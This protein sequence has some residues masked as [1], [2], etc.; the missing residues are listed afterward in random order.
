MKMHPKP[1]ITFIPECF[2]NQGILS[3]SMDFD[4]CGNS[5]CC[6]LSKIVAFLWNLIKIH[7]LP[8]VSQFLTFTILHTSVACISHC[9]WLLLTN[10]RSFCAWV[11][12]GFALF[13]HPRIIALFLWRMSG[14]IAF[15]AFMCSSN[16]L[17]FRTKSWA[18]PIVPAGRRP[19]CSPFRPTSHVG[20]CPCFFKF[21]K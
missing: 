14:S 10:L 16:K 11:L 4:A 3:K 20:L 6:R 12:H 5:Q 19:S 9:C 13:S 17:K 2:C 15:H 21:Y 1:I 18:L 7:W 8:N